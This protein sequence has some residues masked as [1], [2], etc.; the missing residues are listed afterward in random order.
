MIKRTAARILVDQLVIQGVDTIFCVPGESFLAVLDALVDVPQI[1]LVTCRHEG[2]ASMMA[3]AHGKLTGRPGVVFASRGPGTTNASSGLHV[4]IQDSTPYILFIGQNPR[5]V[6]EREAFQEVD[7]R[8]ML[9]TQA[10]LVLQV[11]DA[12]RMS[13]FVTRAFQV[14]I[15]GRPG[16]VVV[17]LPEDMLTDEAMAIDGVRCE[18]P[19]GDPAPATLD[20]I[21]AALEAAE[22]PLLMVGGGDWSDAEADALRRFVE[23]SG[24]PCCATFRRQDKLSND[25]RNYIG[26]IGLGANPKLLARIADADLLVVLGARLGDIG[27]NGY[28]IMTVPRP[29]QKLVHIYPAADEFAHVY[30]PDLAVVARPGRCA[31]ALADHVRVDGSRWAGWTG[32]ARAEF[33]AW[34]APRKTVGA[35]QMCEIVTWLDAHQPD[36]TIYTNGAG[37]FSVWLHRFHRYRKLGTQVAPVCGSMGYGFPAAIAAKLHRPEARV[38]CFAG[39]GDFQMV[40]PELATAMENDAAVI[41]LILNNGILGTIRMHQERSYPGRVSGTTL[42]NGNPDFVKLAQAYGAFGERVETAD[43]FPDAFDRAV[44][45]GVPAVLELMIDPETITPAASLTELREQALASR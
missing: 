2:A 13:E 39:D 29:A 17:A 19:E 24:L 22:R 26:E 43:A 14:A 15:S 11:E 34:T 6:M 1:R 10:K 33:E 31:Q 4:A 7:Y 44:A 38:I 25:H 20:K 36:D 32:T 18:V 37:N 5:D 27:T 41:V 9:A 30:Q 12:A 8:R 45:A 3:E 16:P 28:D 42:K 21:R 35:L 40:L 23:D